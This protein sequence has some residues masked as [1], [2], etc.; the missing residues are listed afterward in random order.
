MQAHQHFATNGEGRVR[1]LGPI[2]YLWL[3]NRGF[4][5]LN[6]MG[7]AGLNKCAEEPCALFVSW[8]VNTGVLRP[9]F[10]GQFP[11]RWQRF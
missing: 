4:L 7:G 3:S 9:H 11:R 2:R 10:W 8:D 6:L 5:W 1:I